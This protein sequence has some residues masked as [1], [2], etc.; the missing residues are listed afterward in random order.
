MKLRLAALVVTVAGACVAVAVAVAAAGGEARGERGAEFTHEAYVWQRAWTPAVI[1]AVR[2][3]G[4]AFD[5]LRVWAA[6]IETNGAVARWAPT[7]STGRVDADPARRPS[8]VVIRVDGSVPVDAERLLAVVNDVLGSFDRRQT[9]HPVRTVEIDHDCATARLSAYASLL[10]AV[11]AALDDDVR[12]SITALPTWISSPALDDVLATVDEVVLQVHAVDDPRTHSLFSTPRARAAVDAFAAHASEASPRLRWRV[13]LPAY[14]SAVALD[15]KGRVIAVESEHGR[16]TNTAAGNVRE[17]WAEP[18]DVAALLRSLELKRPRGLAGVVWFRLP[19]DGDR[20]AWSFATLQAVRAGRDLTPRFTVE[21]RA[22]GGG[23]GGGGDIV[24]VNR[25]EVDAIAPH[26]VAV[27]AVGI[28]AAD[29]VN[30]FAFDQTSPGFSSLRPP[31]IAPGG[32]IVVG[33]VRTQLEV[34]A[35]VAH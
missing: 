1:D 7:R 2:E 17:L 16:R 5:G 3:H 28:V 31:R 21:V 14:G 29:G 32:E 6:E 19:V 25:G 34:V 22:N 27:D 10:R 35:Y 15:D 23:G 26:R 8:T 33:W 13:A 11:R 4:P 20:R 9:P 24:L 12:L 30:G 18:A